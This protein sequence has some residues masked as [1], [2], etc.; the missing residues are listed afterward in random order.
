[1]VCIHVLLRAYDIKYHII[2]YIVC[3]YILS[4]YR[5]YRPRHQLPRPCPTIPTAC[6]T[7]TLQH[8]YILHYI[9]HTLYICFSTHLSLVVYIMYAQ[10]IYYLIYYIYILYLH[11]NL[12]YTIYTHIPIHIYLYTYIMTYI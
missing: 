7:H 1:M 4:C 11:T 8:A 6:K 5:S 12:T 3:Y 10:Y 9:T 2:L